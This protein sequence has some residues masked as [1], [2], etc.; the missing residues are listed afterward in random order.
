MGHWETSASWVGNVRYF[1]HHVC[2]ACRTS[3]KRPRGKEHRCVRCGGPTADLGRKFK[4]PKMSDKIQWR[5]VRLLYESGG[6]WD[7]RRACWRYDAERNT[8]SWTPPVGT[9]REARERVRP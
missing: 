1:T 9:L 7:Y 8:Y 6:Y 2:F 4:P 5:K 3:H